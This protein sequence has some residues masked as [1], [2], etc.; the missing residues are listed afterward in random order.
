VVIPC[1]KQLQFFS[2]YVPKKVK[3]QN[4]E[5][6]NIESQKEHQKSIKVS[7]HQKSIKVS[8]HQKSPLKWSERQKIR[9]TT[10]TYGVL[11]MDTKA[12]GGLG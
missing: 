10:T 8:E 7:E 5:N 3:D 4:Y 1:R 6:Q 2:F 11:P 12:S 9:T